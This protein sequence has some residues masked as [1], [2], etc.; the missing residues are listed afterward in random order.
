MATKER[1]QFE[2]VATFAV[3]GHVLEGSVRLAMRA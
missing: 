3:P 1:R 2:K